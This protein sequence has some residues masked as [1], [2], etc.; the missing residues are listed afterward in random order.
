MRDKNVSQQ[1]L[2]EI[3]EMSQPNVSKALNE[4]DKKCFTLIQVIG[5]A[6]YF[7]ISV[8]ELVHNKKSA[9]IS[10]S[11]RS[12][13]QFIASLLESGVAKAIP[14]S[15][16]EEVYVARK[17][18][19]WMEYVP[20]EEKIDYLAFY[21][22]SYWDVPGNTDDDEAM[23]RSEASLIGNETSYKSVND[24]LHHYTGVLD[25][26]KKGSLTDDTYKT[27]LEDLLSHLRD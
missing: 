23:L 11:Q 4:K 9:H 26:Y 15:E 13:A 14:H 12:I 27:V 17:A 25:A 16:I 8:D 7:H 10:T 21:I 5:I 20:S 24:F 3:L 18:D 2:A 6:E 1:K 19:L 22:P